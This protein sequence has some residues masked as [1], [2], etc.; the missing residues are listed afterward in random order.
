MEGV[1][2][3]PAENVF[4]NPASYNSGSFTTVLDAASA[5]AEPFLVQQGNVTIS[6]VTV[7]G[8]QVDYNNQ[9]FTIANHYIN[10]DKPSYY[11]A[12]PQAFAQVWPSPQPDHFPN[13]VFEPSPSN[14]FN[15]SIDCVGFGCRL[16]AATGSLDVQSNAYC[17]LHLQITKAKASLF[18]PN[19]GVVP[20]AYEFATS[21]P[22]LPQGGPWSYFSGYVNQSAIE[23]QNQTLKPNQLSS[24]SGQAKGGFSQA[25]AGDIL[26]FGYVG[27]ES[28]GHFMVL[29]QAPGASVPLASVPPAG[30]EFP[31]FVSNAYLICV[32][33]CTANTGLHYNDSR[34]NGSGIGYGELYLFTNSADQPVGYIFGPGE[35]PHFVSGLQQTPSPV[36]AISVGRFS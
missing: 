28:N 8:S 16:L 4:G 32:Y 23:S 5:V 36:V 14:T 26:C 27:S 15:N 6:G 11:T 13:A 2:H 35:K 7:S 20:T 19:L 21:L 17:Q 3:M 34:G 31:G 22:V 30:Q 10:P 1:L 25:Q 33:D 9:V 24:Y 29:T 18:P 12:T